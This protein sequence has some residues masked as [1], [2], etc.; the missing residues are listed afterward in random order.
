MKQT[1]ELFLTGYHDSPLLWKAH[2]VRALEEDQFQYDWT[3]L[4]IDSVS[5]DVRA[6]I[7][8]KS[9]GVWASAGLI[10]A[11]EHLASELGWKLSI[12]PSK[13]LVAGHPF[14]AGQVLCT[15]SGEAHAVLRLERAFLNLAGY[16]SGIAWKTR[17]M[18]AQI[19]QKCRSWDKR[20]PVPRLTSTRKT[21]PGYRD[22]AVLAVMAG[23]GHSHRISL[24]GGVLIKE[25]HIAAAGGIARAVSGAKKIA[26]H[27]LKIEIEVRNLKELEV[28]LGQ[29][30]DAVLLDNFQPAEVAHAIEVIESRTHGLTVEVSGGIDSRNLTSY[31]LPGVHVLSSGGLTHSVQVTD[32]SLLVDWGGLHKKGKSRKK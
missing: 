31:L 17:Q 15:W 29:G 8:A 5:R 24:G 2:L 22:L 10:T 16:T 19:E 30:V 28:A 32:L 27:G 6:Q 18:V 9:E 7:V 25:N 13:S 3:T 11:T 14:K 20:H 26:P 21:L 4:G 1:S 23:G 12:T